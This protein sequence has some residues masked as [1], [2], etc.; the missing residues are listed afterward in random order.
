MDGLPDESKNIAAANIIDGQDFIETNPNI[1][2]NGDTL[3]GIFKIVGIVK[4][5][6]AYSRYEA[7]DKNTSNDDAL[8]YYMLLNQF[9][10][11][12]NSSFS[13]MLLGVTNLLMNFLNIGD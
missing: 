6:Y 8:N 11:E 10:S 9:S 5:G 12:H 2:I 13:G 7:I 4:T 3:Y 1:L